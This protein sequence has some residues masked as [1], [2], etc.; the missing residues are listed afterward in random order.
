MIDIELFAGGGGMAVGLRAAGFFPAA[1]YER[2]EES[3]ATLRHNL[4]APEPTL[5]GNV[6]EEHVERFDWASTAE[7]VRLLA[8][9][10]PCQPFSLGGQHKAYND[11]RNLFPEVMRAVRITKPLGILIENVR[12]LIRPLFRAYFEYVL[13]QLECPSIEPKKSERWFDHDRRIRDHQVSL[14][15]E[16]EYRVEFRSLDAADFGV[17]QRRYRVFIVATRRNL[18]AFNFPSPT[19]SRAALL[20]V[21]RTSEYWDLHKVP[22]CQRESVECELQLNGQS[23]TLP[24]KTVR[25]ALCGLPKA[26]KA[27]TGAWM[28]HWIIPGARAYSGHSGSVL[29]WPS[30]TIKAGVHGVPGGENTFVDQHGTF[31]YFTLREAA[32]LQSF[33]DNHFFLGARIHVTRQIGNAVPCILA[34]TLG[35]ALFPIM[36]GYKKNKGA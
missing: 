10:T 27:E 34:K 19:H 4:A 9:G 25:E 28:N 20:E 31:R 17:P 3:C 36:N 21:K 30:K 8:A 35:G 23:A 6:S 1:L 7:G 29:D 16:P 14:G 5:I 24:W 12:G 22:K 2:D 32:R 26:S 33:P 15:Y 11:Q 18:P 13:R